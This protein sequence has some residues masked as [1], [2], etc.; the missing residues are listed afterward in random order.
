MVPG[1]TV[2]ELIPQ[3][4]T[5]R[6][7]KSNV[8]K[9][10]TVSGDAVNGEGSA[11]NS[12]NQAPAFQKPPTD[13]DGWQDVSAERSDGWYQ[14]EEGSWF[15]GILLGRFEMNQLNDDG[16]RRAFYQVKVR[17]CSARMM[18]GKGD[19]ARIENVEKGKILAFDERKA[20]EVIRPHAESDGQYAVFV[21]CIGKEALDK[22]RTFWR[23][24]VKTKT[25]RA[26]KTP[27]RSREVDDDI[28]F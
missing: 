27:L 2:G 9:E 7:A 24:A 26:P 8:G 14:P 12:G 16:K 3:K 10:S 1:G 25:I 5:C 15:N 19:D 13:F 18:V 4:G 6:M 23:F 11:E 22:K 20:M 17:D 21:H 28:P